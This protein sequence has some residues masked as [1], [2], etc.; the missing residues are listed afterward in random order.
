MIVT[1]FVTVLCN[2][3]GELSQLKNLEVPNEISVI[4]RAAY[5]RKKSV[6][7]GLTRVGLLQLRSRD[8]IA[9]YL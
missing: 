4:C 9:M 5:L 3:F 7:N 6:V 8:A 2:R 1:L